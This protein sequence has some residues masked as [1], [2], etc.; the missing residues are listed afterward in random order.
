MSDPNDF[1]PEEEEIAGIL[2]AAF[3]VAADDVLRE[4]GSAPLDARRVEDVIE[5]ARQ[6]FSE[7][8]TSDKAEEITGIA[9]RAILKGA[10]SFDERD[11]LTG[12]PSVARMEEALTDVVRFYSNRYFDEMVE[13]DLR[14][15]LA[16][17]VEETPVDA[18]YPSE[19]AQALFA[20]GLS[21]KSYWV[22]LGSVVASRGWHYGYLKSAHLAG[23]RGYEWDSV[24][25]GRTSVICEAMDG[26][27]FWIADAV[28]LLE[29]TAYSD[30]PEA[31]R[32][33]MAW[34]KA[35]E[36]RDLT[37]DALREMGFLVPPAHP[38]C[39]SKIRVF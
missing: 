13:P 30:D 19:N 21:S 7:L 9:K 3:L 4:A 23:R 27:K 29:G 15:K 2:A 36:V 33:Y 6:R 11:R 10:A 39:R 16:A 34:R 1:V 32:K 14:G 5:Y 26:R 38:H 20:A 22:V 35:D 18:P 28:N 17:L 25:D 31:A 24:V 12:V 37:A 8:V